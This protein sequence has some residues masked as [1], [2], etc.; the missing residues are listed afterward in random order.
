MKEYKAKIPKEESSKL[1]RKK[2]TNVKVN[3]DDVYFYTND[4]SIK[5]L[6][7]EIEAIEYEDILRKRLKAFLKKHLISIISIF[8][9]IIL[10]INQNIA[11]KEIRF[12]NYNTYDED[13]EA[14]VIERLKKIGPFYY[15]N[16][17]LNNINFEIKSEFYD[18]EWIS[19]SKKGAYLDIDIRKQKVPWYE[20]IDD[21]IVGD[22]VASRDAVIKVYY[23]KKGVVLIVESQTV[24]QGEL[25]VSGNLKYHLNQV[26]YIKPQAIIIGEVLEYQNVRVRKH[27]SRT[28][29]SG[30]I[31]I[32]TYFTLFNKKLFSK[33]PYEQYQE[34]EVEVFNFLDFIKLKRSIYYQ[35]EE[36][37]I[38]YNYDDAISYAKS[39]IRK[40]F[41][42][43]LYEQIIFIEL[44]SFIEDSDYYD[45]KFIVKKH[46]NI[47]LFVPYNQG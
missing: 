32:K 3:N 33:L 18:Y 25:L 40:D 17:S 7:K 35:V 36:V 1:S 41:N 2:I 16:D 23:V 19:V 22:F 15:L 24:K 12:I 42:P 27:F 9:I 11:V 31:T 45:F 5:Q 10:L 38:E 4:S 13:V 44:V 34:D 6:I 21:G 47:A 29:R 37:D 46:E 28:D 43:G 14:F 8:I 30:E 26:E 20:D 39:L